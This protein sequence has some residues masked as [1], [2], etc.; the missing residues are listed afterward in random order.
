MPSQ[1]PTKQPYSPP[2]VSSGPVATAT[3]LLACSAPGEFNCGLVGY[4]DGCCAANADE[5]DGACG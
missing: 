3:V 4:A 5:C 1:S 2:R